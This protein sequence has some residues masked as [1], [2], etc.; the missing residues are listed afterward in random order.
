MAVGRLSRVETH[1]SVGTNSLVKATLCAWKRT[2]RS[3]SISKERTAMELRSGEVTGND[4]GSWLKNWVIDQAEL[5]VR[6][7]D[8][9]EP[10]SV[11][12]IWSV[13]L[14][15]IE[16]SERF[17]FDTL[18]H[19]ADSLMGDQGTVPFVATEKRVYHVW[20]AD[21]ATQQFILEVAGW[22]MN[23]AAAGVL[24]ATVYEVLKT[25]VHRLADEARIR[26]DWVPNPL[27][28]QEAVER[29]RWHLI[30]RFKLDEGPDRDGGLTL[31]GEE[32]RSDGSRVVR[33]LREGVRYEVDFVDEAGL[34]T[35]GRVGWTQDADPK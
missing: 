2:P 17:D 27:T 5:E 32:E 10:D 7:L 24:G 25:A 16:P 20:G 6:L 26:A 31:I 19:L 3:G 22:A 15:D 21:A 28:L 14:I 30:N 4:R 1:D 29:G 9:V 11:S 18:G 34:V 8:G 23:H 13:D 33:F 12:E 35:I